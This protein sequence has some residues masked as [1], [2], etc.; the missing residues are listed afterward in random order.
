MH[1]SFCA[2]LSH[3]ATQISWIHFTQ[4]GVLSID[5]ATQAKEVI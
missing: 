5:D 2:Q 1:S 3:E 4:M